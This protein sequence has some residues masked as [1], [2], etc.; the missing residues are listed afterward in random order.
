MIRDLLRRLFR[1]PKLTGKYI[2]ARIT[3]VDGDK[4]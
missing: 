4:R 3:H 1:R 2:V